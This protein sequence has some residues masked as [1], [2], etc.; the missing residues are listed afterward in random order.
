M[1]LGGEMIMRERG[2]RGRF[3]QSHRDRL[4][5]LLDV[6]KR[7]CDPRRLGAVLEREQDDVLDGVLRSRRRRRGRGGHGYDVRY[8]PCL[9]GFWTVLRCVPRGG[10]AVRQRGE[11]RRDALRLF[12]QAHTGFRATLSTTIETL[13]VHTISYC[14]ACSMI[15]AH[16]TSHKPILMSKP[17]TISIWLCEVATQS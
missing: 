6:C 4:G 13:L 11:C 17:A 3:A 2:E 1:W 12:T 8:L 15:S 10:A 16:L 7:L 9:F 5:H 14:R